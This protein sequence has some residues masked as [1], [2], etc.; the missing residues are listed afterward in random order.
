MQSLGHQ[1]EVVSIQDE[2]GALQRLRDGTRTARDYRNS[3]G[4]RL[5]ERGAEAL[6]DGHREIHVRAAIPGVS[7]LGRDPSG[8]KDSI[9]ADPCDEPCEREPVILE[10]GIGADDRERRRG[11]PVALVEREGL[12]HVFEPL[13]RY[14][15]AD[16]DHDWVGAAPV[17]RNLRGEVEQQGHDR[18]LA[19][20]RMGQVL[21][22]ES[23]VRD[24]RRRTYVQRRQSRSTTVAEVRDPRVVGAQQVSR[25]DVVV[26]DGE[27]FGHPESGPDGLAVDRVP[28]HDAPVLQHTPALSVQ[29]PDLVGQVGVDVLGDDLACVAPVR[30]KVAPR[31][32]LARD[33]V[34][35][36]RGRNQLVDRGHATRWSRVSLSRR[37]TAGHP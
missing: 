12:D 11:G 21:G 30:E 13:A 28:Q 14:D 35:R 24:Q 22:I 32:G 3:M 16:R 23:R 36:R 4:E 19:E 10:A 29:S 31:K 37:F 33:G 20:P 2:P 27:P 5:D 7:R 26:A 15:P 34:P 8:E 9:G 17:C 6:V 1:R 18:R 25:R